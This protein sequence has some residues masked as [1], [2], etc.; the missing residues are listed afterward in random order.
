MPTS[1]SAKKRLRQNEKQRVKNRAIRSALKTNIRKLREA[2]VAGDTAK[3]DEGLRTTTRLLD[4]AGASHV[5]HKNKASRLKSRLSQ[6][7]KKAKGK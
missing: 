4:K 6:Y 7:I 3:A 5:I 2:V 1:L